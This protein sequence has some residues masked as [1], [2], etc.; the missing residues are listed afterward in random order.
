MFRVLKMVDRDSKT[1]GVSESRMTKYGVCDGSVAITVFICGGMYDAD[2]VAEERLLM[3]EL[4]WKPFMAEF[5][6]STITGTSDVPCRTVSLICRRSRSQAMS[7][8][9]NVSESTRKD[10]SLQKWPNAYPCNSIGCESA[11]F[12]LFRSS[13]ALRSSHGIERIWRTGHSFTG[14]SLSRKM[15]LRPLTMMLVWPY[16]RRKVSP[17]SCVGSV[18]I[19]HPRFFELKI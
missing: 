11:A 16:V 7:L 3:A 9:P 1:G 12:C 18:N 8:L 17:T 6:S 10:P 15:I 14:L 5:R 13:R 2:W 4:R 19:Q